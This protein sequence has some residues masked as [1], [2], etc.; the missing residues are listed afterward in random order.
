[1]CRR[2]LRVSLRQEMKGL[3]WWGPGPSPQ[4]TNRALFWSFDFWFVSHTG[5]LLF[6]WS[7]FY[8]LCYYSFPN[9]SPFVPPSALHPQTL[10]HPPHL[11][12]C[13]WLVHISSLTSLFPIPFLTFLHL[14]YDY[15]LCFL[16]PV[17]SSPYFSPSPPA[18]HWK[19]SIWCPFLWFC[20]CSSCLL[21]F[22]FKFSYW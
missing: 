13:P 8:W 1:M 15:Q 19:P 6:F 12:S 4:L 10:Q 9:F 17:P 14:F 2:P 21:R 20:S 3:S 16:F 11:S 7:R 18:P 22:F 5:L